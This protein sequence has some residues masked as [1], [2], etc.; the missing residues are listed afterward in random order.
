LWR[1][2]VVPFIVTIDIATST[3]G[4]DYDGCVTIASIKT[5]GS[6]KLSNY[7]WLK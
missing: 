2:N 6:R 1:I 3:I 5:Y 4:V 7:T